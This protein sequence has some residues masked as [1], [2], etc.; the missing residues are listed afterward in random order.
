MDNAVVNTTPAKK[1]GR[2]ATGRTTVAVVFRLS[3][4]EYA[5]AQK[6]AARGDYPKI[7]D[8]LGRQHLATVNTAVNVW[9][10][11]R[12]LAAINHA[13]RELTRNQ[14]PSHGS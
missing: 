5:R 13:D 8:V 9:A 6:I 11:E 1:P 4:L 7:G 2:K 10:K 12:V 3:K 14:P